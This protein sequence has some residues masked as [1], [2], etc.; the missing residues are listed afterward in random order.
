MAAVQRQE[1]IPR[2]KVQRHFVTVVYIVG[3][4]RGELRVLLLRHKKIPSWLPPGGHL[5][6]NE[7]P[8][9]CAIREVREETGLEVE[10]EGGNE[11]RRIVPENETL[12]IPQPHHIQLEQIEKGTHYHIDLVYF[13][14]LV[15][16][17]AI[18]DAEGHG[19][20][21]IKW[22]SRE[23]LLAIPQSEIFGEARK[24]AFEALDAIG[25]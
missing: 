8:H 6:E 9:E 10:L 1:L 7:L 5:E 25:R 19:E 14:K 22:F 18:V 12:L 4:S 20:A 23:E 17:N 11:M 21:G 2:T 13:A 16:G 3:T 15:G 24:W